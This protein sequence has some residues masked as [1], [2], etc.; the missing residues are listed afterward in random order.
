MR[1]G[2]GE[3]LWVGLGL[4]WKEAGRRRVHVPVQPYIFLSSSSFQPGGELLMCAEDEAP[5]GEGALTRFDLTCPAAMPSGMCESQYL[6]GCVPLRAR[7]EPQMRHTGV[8]RS[9]MGSGKQRSGCASS[10]APLQKRRS[11]TRLQTTP[12]YFCLFDA[13]NRYI[14]TLRRQDPLHSYSG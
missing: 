8:S 3:L 13:R 14:L 10:A 2:R 9:G 12:I 5:A 11:C 6:L 7:A 1:A 4:G